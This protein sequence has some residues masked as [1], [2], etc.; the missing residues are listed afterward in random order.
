MGDMTSH[1][2][3]ITA[4]QEPELTK[5]VRKRCFCNKKLMLVD[6]T[7]SG[8]QLRHCSQHRLPETHACTHDFRKS[9]QELLAKQ[10]PVIAPKK[11]ER[12]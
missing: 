6:T 3:P 7:C 8:C 11:I 5:C 9:G 2:S 12:I 4:N 10:N 1:H